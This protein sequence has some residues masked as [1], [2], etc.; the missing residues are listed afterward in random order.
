MRTFLPASLVAAGLLLAGLYFSRPVTIWVDG[1]ALRVRG[2]LVRVGDALRQAGVGVSP[3]DRLS[4]TANQLIPASGAIVLERARPV[5]IWT[6]GLPL[7]FNSPERIPANLLA[8]VDIRLFPGDQLL[9]NGRTIDALQALPRS[10][11]LYLQF[12]PARA[13]NV[14]VNGAEQAM[15]SP[16]E[17]LGEAL[18]AS[19]WALQPGDRVSQALDTPLSDGLRVEI[20]R[21]QRVRIQVERQEVVTRTAA[22]T[23]GGALAEAG[24]ALQGLDF[25]QPA[26]S[27]PLPADGNIRVTRVREELVFKQTTVPFKST[28]S[29]DPNLELDQ[30][31]VLVPGKLGVKVSRERVRLEDGKEVSRQAEGE[32]V[33]SEPQDQVLGY[34]TQIVVKSMSTP[35]GNIEYYRAVPMYAT[36]YSP[37]QQGLGRCSLSTSSG[38]P[39]KKGVVAVT[40]AWYR[41]FKGARVYIPGYGIG[42]I[43]DVGG[44]IPGVYWIDLGYSDEDY[45]GWSQTVTVYF[46]TPAPPSAPPILP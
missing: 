9:V 27:S 38:T 3:D 41:M 26:E 29:A 37:C 45:V 12:R 30:R 43:G 28:Y 18:W 40:L 42:T 25:S 8:R 1:A 24:L 21:A 39:L 11:R 22:G 2:P 32:W 15:Y 7:T 13:L 16:A 4:P 46:L 23:V 31:S 33:A 35:D 14:V 10:D 34:G 36:S 44:G 6:D 5:S 20:M 17:T 19:G